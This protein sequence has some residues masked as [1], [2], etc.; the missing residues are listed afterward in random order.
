ML[1]A[2]YRI[3]LLWKSQKK[4]HKSPIQNTLDQWDTQHPLS[5]SQI[6]E[7]KKHQAIQHKRDHKHTKA[8]T[9]TAW[10]D[11]DDIQ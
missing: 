9:T 11:Q 8:Q 2:F 10:L 5:E 6:N 3:V 7:Y 4:Y 1:D